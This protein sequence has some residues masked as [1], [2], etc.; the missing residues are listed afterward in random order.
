MAL[1][2]TGSLAVLGLD[3]REA[4][5]LG[6]ARKDEATER[7]EERADRLGRKLAEEMHARRD[8]AVARQ[9]LEPHAVLALAGERREMRALDQRQ[10]GDR[11][12]ELL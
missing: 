1:A 9:S 8:A 11:R 4:E 5:R 2:T 7:G 3:G 6:A 12:V 10:H